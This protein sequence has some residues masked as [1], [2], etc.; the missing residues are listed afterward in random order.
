MKLSTFLDHHKIDYKQNERISH[1][2]YVRIGGTASIVA[3]PKYRGELLCLLAFLHANGLPYKIVGNMSNI[4]PPDG[5]WDIC[6][7]STKRLRAVYYEDSLAVAECGVP[8]PAL[9]RSMP[10]N[11]MNPPAE[12]VGIPATV[13]GAVYQ[14]AGA[15]GLCISDRLVYADIYDPREDRVVRID[16]AQMSFSYRRSDIASKGILLSAAIK[17]TDGD[18]LGAEERMKRFSELRQGSQ[19]SAPSLGSVFL[20]VDG[21]SAAYYIDEA[22]LKGCRI[23]GASVSLKHAGFIINEGNASAKDYRALIALV[24][25]RV[26]GRFGI[27]LQTEIEIIEETEEA[28]W[29]RFV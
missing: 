22:G 3:Y 7:I 21:V 19:P 14:N 26:H 11:G 8:L 13:G 9:C 2:S 29:L 12:L 18:P 27:F 1:L 10:A 28:R 4:L 5:N 24:R 25:S 20:R 6:L 15:F 17:G 23:G 16:R